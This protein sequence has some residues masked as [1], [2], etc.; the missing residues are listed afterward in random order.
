MVK[1]K[2]IEAPSVILFSL[3]KLAKSCKAFLNKYALHPIKTLF[4]NKAEPERSPIFSE[5][6]AFADKSTDSVEYAKS[7]NQKYQGSQTAQAALVETENMETTDETGANYENTFMKINYNLPMEES[8]EVDSEEVLIKS[9]SDV[10]FSNKSVLDCSFSVTTDAIANTKLTT[11]SSDFSINEMDL[12]DPAMIEQSFMNILYKNVG[13]F[14]TDEDCVEKSNIYLE[15]KRANS[16]TKNILT[17]QKNVAEYRNREKSNIDYEPKS[18]Q[19]KSAPRK[20]PF[21]HINFE[22]DTQYNTENTNVFLAIPEPSYTFRSILQIPEERNEQQN[23]QE[24]DIGMF[25]IVPL[26]STSDIEN[27]MTSGSE[28]LWTVKAESMI[29][30]DADCEEIIESTTVDVTRESLCLETHPVSLNGD[31]RQANTKPD[32]LD[33]I[34]DDIISELVISDFSS[35]ESSLSTPILKMNSNTS[36]TKTA[37]LYILLGHVIYYVYLSIQWMLDSTARTSIFTLLLSAILLNRFS[38]IT[39]LQDYANTQ[40]IKSCVKLLISKVYPLNR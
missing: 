18:Y 20:F 31:L 33:H 35:E 29:F 34:T 11:S 21:D 8:I 25:E 13:P 10:N 36:P 9:E 6:P 5:M 32:S 27:D 16:D 3:H 1:M 15:E 28:Q 26:S 17:E 23:L 14:D 19:D 39:S 37:L 30:N 12:I 24:D 7:D 4:P 38:S 22:I 40:T 2:I